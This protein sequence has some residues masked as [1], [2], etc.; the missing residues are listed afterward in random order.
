M[1]YPKQKNMPL[2]LEENKF[3]WK[4]HDYGPFWV[5]TDAQGQEWLFKMRGGFRAYRERIAAGILD[6]IGINTQASSYALLPKKSGPRLQDEQ[7]EKTQLAILMLEPHTPQVDLSGM[8]GAEN[9]AR[10]EIL[11]YLLG[12]M[13]PSDYIFTKD[14]QCYII[15]NELCFSTSPYDPILELGRSPL[16]TESEFLSETVHLCRKLEQISA[17]KVQKL[18]ALPDSYKFKKLW[19]IKKIVFQVVDNAKKCLKKYA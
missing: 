14:H 3:L 11:A 7:I 4:K 18:C 19:N 6:E 10:L 9:I 16:L 2:L 1:T 8:K 5:A 13:E 17:D 15:D 12:A